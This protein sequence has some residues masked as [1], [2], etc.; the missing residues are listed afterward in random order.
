MS[1]NL[2]C[3]K[4]LTVQ[5]QCIAYTTDHILA[6]FGS[7]KFAPRLQ[8]R[9][10]RP[11]TL[12]VLLALLIQTVRFKKTATIC[13]AIYKVEHKIIIMSTCKKDRVATVTVATARIATADGPTLTR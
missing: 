3:K 12:T 9:R 7:R 5:T 6:V 1:L 11:T 13:N 8:Y 2:Q 4:S 10:H